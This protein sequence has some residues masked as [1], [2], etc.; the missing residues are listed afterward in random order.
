MMRQIKWSEAVG[1][2]VANV[3]DGT[4][5]MAITFTDGTFMLVVAEESYGD[6]S[7]VS[8][9]FN[10]L[11]DTPF[12][13]RRAIALGILSE[14]ELKDIRAEDNHKRE[15]ATTTAER[16]QYELLKAKYERSA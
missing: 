6:V 8:E 5:S 14:D 7:V 9:L 2:T 12:N 1:K 15:V 16:R 10:P 13:R 4:V 11:S 3:D